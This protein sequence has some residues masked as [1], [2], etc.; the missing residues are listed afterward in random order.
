MFTIF[1]TLADLKTIDAKTKGTSVNYA[2]PRTA[3]STIASLPVS[4]IISSHNS[5]S[6][7]CMIH[8]R[9]QHIGISDGASAI[10]TQ[11]KT[12]VLN[13]NGFVTMRAFE[14]DLVF[15]VIAHQAARGFED[16]AKWQ[17]LPGT[18]S[19][20]AYRLYCAHRLGFVK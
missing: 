14:L 3:A 6:R 18:L 8:Q 16:L 19:D 13:N 7:C 17:E 15:G 10:L 12:L 20:V 5:G 1:E 2:F 9:I 11:R 4:R